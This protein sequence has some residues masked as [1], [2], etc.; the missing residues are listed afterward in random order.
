MD[1]TKL[2]SQILCFSKFLVDFTIC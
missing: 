2:V 1:S